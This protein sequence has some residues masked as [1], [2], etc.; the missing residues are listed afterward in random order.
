M[1]DRSVGEWEGA[2]AHARRT[3]A[4]DFGRLF[5]FHTRL[6]SRLGT[7]ACQS[8]AG[9]KAGSSKKNRGVRAGQISAEA[10]SGCCNSL[11]AEFHVDVCQTLPIS[12]SIGSSP[13][14]L[15]SPAVLRSVR[16]PCMHPAEVSAP[17]L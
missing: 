14:P 3:G 15:L 9:G 6:R 2:R 7:K 10:A 17:A 16:H 11:S 12:P 1:R 8:R 13:L 5:T 4:A